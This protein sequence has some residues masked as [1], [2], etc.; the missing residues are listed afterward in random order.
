MFNP[1]EINILVVDDTPDNLRLLIKMLA[2]QG[3][4]V[5]P[6]PNGVFALKSIQA[7]LPDIVL[8]D[9]MMP[10]M[11]GY[12]VCEELKARERTREIPV[13]FISALNEV[14]DKVKAFSVGGVD[15]ITKPF[16]AEEVCARVKTHLMIRQQQQYIQ[17]QNAAL[18][19][20]SIAA[21]ELNAKLQQEI[22]E[23]QRA[24][25]ELA[26]ANAELQRLAALDGLTRLANRRRFDEYL[27]Q[28]WKRHV[29]EQLPLSLILC[30]IDYFK[31]HNDTYGHLAGDECLK[32]VAQAMNAAVKRPA[33]LT[34]RYGGEEFVVVLPNTDQHGA[35]HVARRIQEH[36]QRL[37]IPHASS[38]VS[39]YV[40]L[41]IGVATIVPT[42]D[43]SAEILIDAADNALYEVKEHGR[44][45][46]LAK[47]PVT[48]NA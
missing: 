8:L 36:I 22:L 37:H 27:A 19:I 17:T 13:I 9:V 11:N 29:R 4:K 7:V 25:A 44:N 3:Y 24:E 41:S 35:A 1:L 6:A 47:S 43:I 40:T 14:F 16:Y 28:E 45:A 26:K 32:Q 20:Q 2:E 48:E 18:E 15:Y 42:N 31:R 39:Q 46:I 33:D 10:E 21:L 23:R 38:S 5:R 12:S 30:D 34:A